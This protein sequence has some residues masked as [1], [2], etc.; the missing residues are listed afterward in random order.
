M[1]KLFGII[2]CVILLLFIVSCS[3]PTDQ[4]LGDKKNNKTSDQ[5]NFEDNPVLISTD[6]YEI[7][8]KEFLAIIPALI[9]GEKLLYSKDGMKRALKGLLEEKILI[10]KAK[11]LDYEN[12]LDYQIKVETLEKELEMKK[13]QS[14]IAIMIKKEVDK[15]YKFDEK[16]LKNYYKLNKIKFEKRTFSEI[17]RKVKDPTDAQE[18]KKVEKE[19]LM[20]YKKLKNGEKFE[21]LAKEYYNGAE[22]IRLRNGQLGLIRRGK[23]PLDFEE[24]GYDKLKK[25][26]DISKPFL[27][28]Q[29]WAIIRLERI[30][31]FEE[32]KIYIKKEYERFLRTK[33]NKRIID[34]YLNPLKYKYEYSDLEIEKLIPTK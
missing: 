19:I 26:G 6:G 11:E 13:R 23:Y 5:L 29:G 16:G 21:D 10:D 14:L 4:P 34:K 12:D 33:I 2:T 9:E 1:K 22:Y 3:N 30:V 7:T 20:I 31:G 28:N 32:Q 15:E 25:P 24:I 8:K 18:V 27:Y 17:L